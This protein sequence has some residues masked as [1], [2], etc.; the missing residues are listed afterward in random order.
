VGVGKPPQCTHRP[1]E[2]SLSGYTFAI[3][4]RMACGETTK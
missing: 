2:A 1:A 3:P 4:M